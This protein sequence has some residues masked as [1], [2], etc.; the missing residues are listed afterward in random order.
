MQLYS[1]VAVMDPE[2]KAKLAV[3]GVVREDMEPHAFCSSG[4]L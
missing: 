1:A 4:D 3:L 2:T